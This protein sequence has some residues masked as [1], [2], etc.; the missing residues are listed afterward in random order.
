MTRSASG[1]APLIVS[2]AVNGGV[3]TAADTP[4]VP[5]TPV[6]IARSTIEAARAGAAIAHIHVRDAAGKPSGEVG[7]YNEAARLIR[8]ECDVILNFSTDLRVA[9]G[10]DC[11]LVGPE[12][13]SLPVGSVNLG[14]G[15]IAAPVPLVRKI[16][17]LMR[18][19]G[20]RPELEIFHEGMLGTARRLVLEGAVD[21]PIMCQFC[22]GLEGGAPAE[23]GALLRMIREVPPE[24][25]WSVAGEGEH[26]TAMAA[27][28]IAL[29]G[30]VRVGI[31]DSPYYLRDELAV[32]NAQLVERVI[33]LAVEF[34]RNVASAAE[35]RTMLGIGPP[36][37]T[38]TASA[39]AD[40]GSFAAVGDG[41]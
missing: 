24:W 40:D 12:I 25:L 37:D 30:H 18:T 16:A 41:S 14:D 10:T 38:R 19:A 29:G 3:L 11:L 1:N 22:L 33:R 27:L 5:L 8:R 6:E 35:A 39:R 28:G 21:E 23:P 2:V 32:S 34:G 26:A 15:M 13:A 17:A 20:V 36:G 31:E 9:S 7:L 4:H